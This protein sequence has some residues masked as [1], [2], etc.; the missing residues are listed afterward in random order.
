MVARRR[1]SFRQVAVGGGLAVA[2]SLVAVGPAWAGWESPQAIDNGGSGYGA[3]T[4]QLALT[5]GPNGSTTALFFQPAPGTPSGALGTPFMVR[6]GGGS[7]TAW[8][9]PAAVTASQ[10]SASSP[11]PSLAAAGG[12]PLG[13]GGVDALLA[14]T[15][16]GGSSQYVSSSWPASASQPSS[17][18]P[19]PCTT[20]SAPECAGSGSGN[21]QVAFDA[22]GNAYAVG[23]VTSAS[24]GGDLLFA[25]TDS[26]GTWAPAQ[27]IA[28]GARSPLLAVDPAGDVVV[29]Y[30]R[31]DTSIP[32]LN[33]VHEYAIRERTGDTSFSSEQPISGPNSV[34]GSPQLV[35]DASGTATAVFLEDTLPPT[36][37]GPIAPVLQAVRWPLGDSKPSQEQPVSPAETSGGEPPADVALTVDPQARVTVAWDTGSPQSA[38]YAAQFV[39][40]KWPSQQVS[41]STGDNM[42]AVS[43]AADAD[44]TVTLVYQDQGPPPSGTVDLEAAQLPLGGAWSKPVTL[45]STETGAGALLSNSSRVAAMP[46]GRADVIFLQALKGTNRLFATRFVDRTPPAIEIVTP[47]DGASYK[48]GATVVADYSCSDP[49]SA[50][51]SCNG[52]VASGQPIDTSSPGSHTFTVTGS[53]PSGNTASK[54]VSYT[55]RAGPPPADKTPPRITISAPRDGAVY[56]RSQRVIARFSCADPDSAV[57]VCRGT[58]ASGAPIDTRTVGRHSFSVTAQDPSGNTASIT[59]HYIVIASPKLATIRLVVAP[60]RVRVGKKRVRIRF[61]AMTCAHGRCHGLRTARVLFD[62]RSAR[63]NR[64]G[65][66]TFSVVL[67]R[68]GRYVGRASEPGYRPAQAVVTARRAR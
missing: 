21:A 47:Q 39:G 46:S 27:I 28:K 19:A 49:D 33:D 5:D 61:R 26:T 50:V 34:S 48:Q 22:A 58:T 25:R 36:T 45:N 35:I 59:V 10:G 32:G 53:D 20:G 3:T 1:R 62:G 66:A 51:S 40:G 24:G 17:T 54:T 63:T 64:A 2:C 9:S 29:T 67:R 4:A 38:V 42:S 44:G 14:L 31:Q 12:G 15:T 30:L 11:G 52:P 55:V 56:T 7:S 68:P 43:V 16:S 18:V 6:R 57:S 37:G 41:P 23:V 60:R 13:T 65:Y 8:G